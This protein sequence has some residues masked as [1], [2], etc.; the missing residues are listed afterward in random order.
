MPLCPKV[1]YLPVQTPPHPYKHRLTLLSMAARTKLLDVNQDA[2]VS[3][4]IIFNML[5][6][7]LVNNH[8]KYNLY[9]ILNALEEEMQPMGL[10]YESVLSGNNATFLITHLDGKWHLI[11]ERLLYRIFENCGEVKP[12]FQTSQDTLKVTLAFPS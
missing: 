2:D 8:T 6:R 1:L 11:A 5:K 4:E 9:S 10:S 12:T 3:A 7:T